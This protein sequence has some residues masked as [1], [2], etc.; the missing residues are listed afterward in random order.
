MIIKTH[1]EEILKFVGYKEKTKNV[2]KQLR[3]KQTVY[4]LS[5]ASLHPVDTVGSALSVDGLSFG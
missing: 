4:I 2:T 5:T 3:Q 1:L